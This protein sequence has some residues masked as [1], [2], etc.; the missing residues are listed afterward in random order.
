MYTTSKKSK[1]VSELE[2]EIDESKRPKL[3]SI[4]NIEGRVVVLCLATW[5]FGFVFCEMSPFSQYQI[6]G[7]QWGPFMADER[8]I[9]PCFGLIPFGA[10]LGVAIA[11]G[12]IDM[13][14]RR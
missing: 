3:K 14:D 4:E 13:L 6:L 11:N 8:G 7:V 2:I 12:I 1:M 5:Y 9:G 10:A